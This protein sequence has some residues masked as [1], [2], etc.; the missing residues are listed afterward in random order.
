MENSKLPE[1]KI[2]NISEAM[3][4]VKETTRKNITLS[5]DMNLDGFHQEENLILGIK[6][7]SLVT[8]SHATGLDTRP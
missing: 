2:E 3:I 8:V 5:E 6:I 7:L 1:N 4:L